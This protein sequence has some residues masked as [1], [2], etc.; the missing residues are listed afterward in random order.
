MRYKEG[1]LVEINVKEITLAPGN[2][3]VS[4]DGD[5]SEA[6]TYKIMIL[7]ADGKIAPQTIKKSGKN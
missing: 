3:I 7:D 1:K 6:D 4:F 5:Y 2:S